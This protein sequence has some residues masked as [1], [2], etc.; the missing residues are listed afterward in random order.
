MAASHGAA[1]HSMAASHSAASHGAASHNV[2][3]AKY[4][5]CPDSFRSSNE[6]G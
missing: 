4:A 1:S 6:T 3:G 2:T 5:D